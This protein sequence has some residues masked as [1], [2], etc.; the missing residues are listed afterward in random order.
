[1]E[2]TRQNLQNLGDQLDAAT[3]FRWLIDHVAVPII[4]SMP[5]IDY[6]LLDSV[7]KKR[8]VE[9]FISTFG[10]SVSHVHLTASEAVLQQRYSWRQSAGDDY[11]GSISYEVAVDHANERASRSLIDVAHHVIDVSTLS[12]DQ[13]VYDVIHLIR[14]ER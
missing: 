8:Q 12:V 1:L 10:S 6:W 3:D 4:E 2:E 9:H 13:S 7:R 14:G 11:L 5:T